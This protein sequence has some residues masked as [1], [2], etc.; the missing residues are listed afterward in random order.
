MV[1]ISDGILSTPILVFGWA[2]SI[3][4]MAATIWWSGRRRDLAEEIPKLSVMTAAFFI[5]SLIH[6][7]VGPTSVHFILSGLLGVVLGVLAYPAI[8]IGVVLQAFLFQHGGVTTIGVNTLIMGISALIAGVIFRAPAGR[9]R[10]CEVSTGI[11]AALAG[12]VGVLLAA[13]F[14]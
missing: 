6:I 12:G 1:H 13:L 4:V 9:L 10:L 3:V 7:P 11:V 8:F 14:A 5:A 2:I